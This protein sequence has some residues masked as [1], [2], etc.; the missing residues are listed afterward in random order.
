MVK[1][2]LFVG[3][4]AL[5]FACSH[6]AA[7]ASSNGKKAAIDGNSDDL[8]QE[9]PDYVG[10]T[11]KNNVTRTESSNATD[12]KKAVAHALEDSRQ[13]SPNKVIK[14]LRKHRTQITIAVAIF[15]FR[16]ELR[17]YLWR[18]ISK[19]V[20]DP[21]TGE[22]IRRTIRL[23]AILQLI[24]FVDSMRRM[25]S[26]L[27][28]S[29]EDSDGSEES[30]ALAPILA[31]LLMGSGRNPATALLLS[32]LGGSSNSA[33]IPPV[34]QHYTFER[35]NDRYKKDGMALRKAIDPTGKK[36]LVPGKSPPPKN[37]TSISD[38]LLRG[39]RQ[40]TDIQEYNE[41][42]VIMDLSNLDTSVS[43]MEVI[44]DEVTFLLEMHQSGQQSTNSTAEAVSEPQLDEVVLLLESPGGSAADYALASQQILRLRKQGIKVTICVD[45]VA[46]S[47]TCFHLSLLTE[48]T[49]IIVALMLNVDILHRWIHD[50]LYV[51]SGL[52]LCSTIRG[53]RQYR[54]DWTNV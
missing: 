24:V 46:A 7:G 17:H 25:Q 51:E 23:T 9:N 50:C 30:N 47:G 29:Q 34:Q 20:L 32:K 11:K 13:L 1:R 14:F 8:L 3:I 45:K 19:P 37:G 38:L 16:R 48:G 53:F 28:K 21:E 39:R 31:L 41:T 2:F 15:A 49:H 42:V 44:R 36:M 26:A 22:E 6:L 10:P 12:I 4:A 35:I 54:C 18:M 40:A 33:Y 52:S 5:F 27:R 43:Q